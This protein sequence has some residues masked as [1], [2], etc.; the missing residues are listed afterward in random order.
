MIFTCFT[1]NSTYGRLAL[2]ISCCNNCF[3]SLYKNV[4]AEKDFGVPEWKLHDITIRH[5]LYYL[6]TNE[7]HK[8]QENIIIAKETDIRTT[9]FALKKSEKTNRHNQACQAGIAVKK[10]AIVRQKIENYKKI[11]KKVFDTFAISTWLENMDD[12]M[13]SYK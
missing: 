9:R 11:Y 7:R 5:F 3:Y 13:F 10:V 12:I 8:V 1:D 2:N 4:N 6:E